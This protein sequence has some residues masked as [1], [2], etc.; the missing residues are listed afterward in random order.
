MSHFK[1][2]RVKRNLWI[3]TCLLGINFGSQIMRKFE[4]FMDVDPNPSLCPSV[5]F[6]YGI[7][8]TN[9][10]LGCHISIMCTMMNLLGTSTWIL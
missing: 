10:K 5:C 9:C 6:L 8:I 2:G 3:N 4:N 1:S 7:E